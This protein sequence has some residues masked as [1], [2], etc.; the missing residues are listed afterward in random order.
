[1][2]VVVKVGKPSERSRAGN[3]GKRD[4]QILLMRYL[5]RVHFN[6]PMSPL[7]L[8]IYHQMQNDPTFYE[9]IFTVD[10]DTSVTAKSL[11]RLVAASVSDSNIIGICGETRLQNGGWTVHEY[12]ISHNLSKAFKSLFGSVS[13]LPGCF[14][15]YRVRTNDKGRPLIIS[16][17]VIDEYA[18]NNVDTLHERTLFSLGEDRFLMM[19]LTKHFPTFKTKFIPDA[20]VPTMAPVSW[21]VLFSQRRCWINLTVHNLCEFAILPDLCRICR[22]SM[23]FFIYLDLIGTLVRSFQSVNLAWLIVEAATGQSPFPLISIIM[24]AAVYGLQVGSYLPIRREF[25]LVG[26]MVVYLISRVK[27]FLYSFFLL[28]YSFWRMD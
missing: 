1:Y 11:N 18:D 14:T 4:S 12:Y 22:F 2:I 6:A 10:A 16:N 28:I 3:P 25:M 15:L 17:H 9:C 13:C 8:K 5:N 27:L 23:R 19:L 21:R 26:W 20:I 24:L 7:E